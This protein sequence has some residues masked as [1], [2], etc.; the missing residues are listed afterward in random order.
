MAIDVTKLPAYTEEHR[1][2]LLRNAVVGNRTAKEFN[3]YTGLKGKTALNLLN[4]TVTFGDGSS[5]GWNEAGKSEMSQRTI[6]PG[7]LKVNMS[8]CDKALL[9]TW[10][11]YGVRIAAGQK[12]LPFEEDFMA[13]VI[14]GIK[15]NLE[16]A[17]WQGDTASED[18][19][20]NKFDGM[21]KILGEAEVAGTYTVQ[22]ADDITTIINKT[23]ALIPSAA[24]EKGEVVMY[25]GYDSYRDYIQK[26]LANGN[27]VITN[28][29]NDVAM[30]TSVLIPGSNVRVIPVGGLDN[31][32]LKA[33][34]SYRDNFIY[35]VDLSGDDEKLDMWYS[36]DNREFRLA[37]EF[38]AG[39]QV[40]YPDMVAVAKEA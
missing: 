7:Y 29:V 33:V 8:F 31:Q 26:L 36:Q 23:Y 10:A 22:A 28:V 3:L 16:K 35:G 2:P 34:A 9:K 4:T 20:L 24:Y 40:A 13:G 17:M 25:V 6:E 18:A 14:D 12:T 32:K 30:P 37:V 21:I 27:L 5:C 39:V 15:A 1:L 11:N 19:N 38:L